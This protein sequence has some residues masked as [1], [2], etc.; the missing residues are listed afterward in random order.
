VRVSCAHCVAHGAAAASNL[1][2]YTDAAYVAHR[3]DVDPPPPAPAPPATSD[4]SGDDGGSSVPPS[5]TPGT[6]GA[7][8]GRARSDTVV[9]DDDGG[10][11]DG[12]SD[13]RRTARD[14][15][16]DRLL[17]AHL[18][19]HRRQKQ[20]AELELRAHRHRVLRHALSRSSPHE[21]AAGVDAAQIMA[22]DDRLAA[23]C[24]Q[25]SF[26]LCTVTFYAIHA[27]NLTCSP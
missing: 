26:L 8:A 19:T 9:G 17:E 1:P 24:R 23:A 21:S 15:R 11:A 13:D 5:P 7:V 14:A 18:R 4:G 6:A 12:G 3:D 20:M 10:S 2:V 25:V 16:T 22:G 27:H